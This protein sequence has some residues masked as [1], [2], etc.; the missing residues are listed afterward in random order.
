MKL[1][2]EEKSRE[3]SSKMELLGY[4][5]PYFGNEFKKDQVEFRTFRPQTRNNGK[6]Y[7]VIPGTGLIQ[8]PKLDKDGRVVE[9]KFTGE[10][11][12]EE[13]T[14]LYIPGTRSIFL[15]D[16]RDQTG[17]EDSKLFDRARS[18]EFYDG[19]V[20]CQYNE[21]NKIAYL[22]AFGGNAESRGRIPNI[23]A[24]LYY[25][26][27]MLSSAERYLKS[28]LPKHD[29]VGFVADNI[30]SKNNAPLWAIL[31]AVRNQSIKKCQEVY[32]QT[33]MMHAQILKMAKDNPGQ[34]EPVIFSEE[35]H[36]KIVILEAIE[37]GYVKELAD[38]WA[39][40]EG[41]TLAYISKGAD[42]IEALLRL[43]PHKELEALKSKVGDVIDGL[44]KD[45]KERDAEIERILAENKRLRKEAELAR[46]VSTDKLK[47]L[48]N[49]KGYSK[50]EIQ[51][52]FEEIKEAGGNNVVEFR[53]PNWF[54][55]DY[56]EK[57]ED[58]TT[59]S[60]MTAQIVDYY[61]ENQ[62]DFAKLLT[63]L[64]KENEPVS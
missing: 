36:N 52:V 21:Q 51:K 12:M 17:Q 9:N 44:A 5:N 16:L 55:S 47:E 58:G 56:F 15:S 10:V 6:L 3:Y 26:R 50:E 20:T 43:I 23:H 24:K 13:E 48:S 57:K 4:L 27:D 35:G 59:K 54:T 33:S 38:T 28:V 41:K 2:A 39:T 37:R 22:R 64:Q 25:E 42:P 49:D 19:Y 53:K 31:A 32:P 61:F 34:L 63:A 45:Q 8:V 11:E 14:I 62:S 30:K 60:Y 1:T 40:A 7:N 18:I 46:S 29:V